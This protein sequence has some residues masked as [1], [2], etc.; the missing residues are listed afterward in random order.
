MVTLVRVV[1]SRTAPGPLRFR[2]A[3]DYF[4]TGQMVPVYSPVNRIRTYAAFGGLPKY[5]MSVRHTF[6]EV[7]RNLGLEVIT[8]TMNE[9]F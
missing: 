1:A 8:R 3:F 4:D 5:L 7:A 9:L 2:G 6:R